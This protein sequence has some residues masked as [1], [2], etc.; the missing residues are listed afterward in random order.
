MLWATVE[1]G[2]GSSGSLQGSVECRGMQGTE[3]Q[4]RTG[5]LFNGAWV[6]EEPQGPKFRYYSKIYALHRP[7]NNK[8][9]K[10]K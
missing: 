10:I 1:Y 8:K 2:R 6:A 4:A 9:T 5:G 3:T 7:A